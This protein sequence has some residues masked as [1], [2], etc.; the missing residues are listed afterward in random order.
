MDYVI[1]ISDQDGELKYRQPTVEDLVNDRG[2]IEG[3]ASVYVNAVS[4][5]SRMAIQDPQPGNRSLIAEHPL[6]R[7]VF[8]SHHLSSRSSGTSL[9]SL[10]NLSLVTQLTT[11]KCPQ[12]NMRLCGWYSG[13]D[14]CL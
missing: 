4:R 6:G 8:R 13:C 11:A 5:A 3:I 10:L 12:R 1:S 7:I 14:A 9:L 2:A